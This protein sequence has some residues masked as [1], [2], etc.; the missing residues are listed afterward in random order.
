MEMSRGCPPSTGISQTNLN[1]TLMVPIF[2]AFRK[3]PSVLMADRLQAGPKGHSIETD[4]SG[5]VSPE[6]GNI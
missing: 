6:K 5:V 3:V 1:M 2:E 4:T